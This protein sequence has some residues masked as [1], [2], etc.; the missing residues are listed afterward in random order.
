MFFDIFSLFLGILFCNILKLPYFLG[1]RNQV[2]NPYKTRSRT[3]SCLLT[4]T[5]LGTGGRY[6]ILNR[7]V[8]SKL[9]IYFILHSSQAHRISVN[10]KVNS[11]K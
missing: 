3:I 4:L 8:A 1:I 11:K 5:L 10:G 6:N 7:T 9:R 2:L